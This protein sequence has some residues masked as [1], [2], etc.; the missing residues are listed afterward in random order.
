[1]SRSKTPASRMGWLQKWWVLYQE[2]NVNLTSLERWFR[3]WARQLKTQLVIRIHFEWLWPF[4]I[5]KL[6]PCI[7]QLPW[8]TAMCPLRVPFPW[9]RLRGSARH[10]ECT[11][12]P[13]C[14]A[15]ISEDVP[16]LHSRS[17]SIWQPWS[18]GTDWIRHWRKKSMRRKWGQLLSL[19]SRFITETPTN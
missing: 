8:R 6:P 17:R 18:H 11:A 10:P 16:A 14:L 7:A 1:M 4:L 19:L 13:D 5:C 2:F 9:H 15:P 3:K 12:A